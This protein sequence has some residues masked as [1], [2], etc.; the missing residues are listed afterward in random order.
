[1]SAKAKNAVEETEQRE[2]VRDIRLMC[3]PPDRASDL[4]PAVRKWIEDAYTE[5][6][7]I[8]PEDILYR[9]ASGKMLLWVVTIDN[10]MVAALVTMLIQKKSGLVCSMVAA[11]GTELDAWT[12]FHT[13]IEDYARKERCVKVILEGRSGWGKQLGYQET[14]RVFEKVL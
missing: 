8:M 10:I 13:K 2:Q 7:E 6:D 4:W 11:G 1:M 9:F 12:D 3:A 14:R 5:A